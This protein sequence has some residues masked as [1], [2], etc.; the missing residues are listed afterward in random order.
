MMNGDILFEG[1]PYA[2]PGS[3]PPPFDWNAKPDMSAVP[4]AP[5]PPGTPGTSGARGARGYR[6]AGSATVPTVSGDAL[7]F[8]TMI[9]VLIVLYDVVTHGTAWSGVFKNISSHLANFVSVKPLATVQ[10]TTAAWS[11]V[12]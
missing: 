9:F 7:K 4:G 5:G 12:L 11:N 1:D 6:A 8:I 2:D 10:T 3:V